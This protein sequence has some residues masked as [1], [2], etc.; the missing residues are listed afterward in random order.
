MDNILAYIKWRK[1]IRFSERAFNDVDALIFSTLAYAHWDN[2]VK[3]EPISL[4]QASQLFIHS[5][6]RMYD[7][8]RYAHSPEIP[9]LVEAMIDANRYANVQIKNYINILDKQEEVQFSAVTF[10]LED[11][12]IVIA[13][14]GTDCTILGWKEDFYMSYKKE[15]PAQ[16]YAL[17]YLEENAFTQKNRF[18]LFSK[19]PRKVYVVGHSKGGNLAMYATI[20]AAS[21]HDKI[22]RVYNF[23]GPGFSASFYEE[24]N[25]QTIL[26]KIKAYL[27]SAAI[28]GRLFEHKEEQVI[29]EGYETGLLQHSPFCW[30]VKNDG[31][32]KAEKLKTQSDAHIAYINKI[33][34]SKNDEQKEKLIRNVFDTLEKLKI[35]EIGDLVDINLKRGW[36]SIK[37]FRVM[38][39]EDKHFFISCIR[40]IFTQTKEVFLKMK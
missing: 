18:S 3:Q 2:I 36:D 14:R 26:P 25:T 1:D 27:P 7:K 23:D 37:E 33:L 29:I 20:K 6:E 10:V 28:V 5:E 13:Y 12:S 21:S 40:F 30:Q 31:F 15:I 9:E 17:K 39:N 4:G 34:L 8:R 32:V 24:N 11:G 19:K 16:R 38:S 22:T 35:E